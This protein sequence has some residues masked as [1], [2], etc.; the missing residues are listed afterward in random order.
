MFGEP[1]AYME[2]ANQDK[3]VW[4]NVK[5]ADVVLYASE[6][7]MSYHLG[8]SAQ[9]NSRLSLTP[10]ECQFY[11]DFFV[12]N[13][14]VMRG[15]QLQ[16]APVG[17]NSPYQI[18]QQVSDMKGYD[19][20]GNFVKI[21]LS[22]AQHGFQVLDA[23]KVPQITLSTTTGRIHSNSNDSAS[24]PT[25]SW[26]NNS[27]VG[28]YH[29]A[30][31]IIGFANLGIQ[32]ARLESYGRLILSNQTMFRTGCNYLSVI[33][34]IYS[35]CNVELRLATESNLTRPTLTFYDNNRDV[36]H[37]GKSLSNAFIYTCNNN[38]DIGTKFQSHLFIDPFGQ[39]GLKTI[40]PTT[41]LVINNFTL[42]LSNTELQV[43]NT[44]STASNALYAAI[45]AGSS[46]AG[47]CNYFAFGYRSNVPTLIV[48]NSND[49]LTVHLNGAERLRLNSNNG[50]LGIF[51]NAPK[52]QVDL[53][54]EARMSSNVF[55]TQTP[56]GTLAINTE[57]PTPAHVHIE[58]PPYG[59][60]YSGPSNNAGV[61]INNT[62]AAGA[63][64]THS[65]MCLQTNEGNPF[66]SFNSTTPAPR[67]WSVGIDTADSKKL[68][69]AMS[70]SN[71]ARNTI[72]TFDSNLSGSGFNVGV[73]T[74][75]PNAR[76]VV[77][78]GG[79][80]E[81]GPDST[82]SKL[83]VQNLTDNFDNGYIGTVKNSSDWVGIGYRPVTGITSTRPEMRVSAQA[84]PLIYRF[85]NLARMVSM[86]TTFNGVTEARMGINFANLDQA[87][88]VYPN[89]ALEVLG[90]IR[91]SIDVIT[92][93]DSRLKANLA[94]IPEPLKKVNALTGYTYDRTDEPACQEQ[95]RHVGLIAQQVEQVLPE[96]V[97]TDKSSGHLSIA[98]GN[99]TALLVEA[100]K[101][102]TGRMDRLET[103]IESLKG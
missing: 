66:V 24:E 42:P 39:I 76:L 52:Y 75:N 84:D 87:A 48:S 63:T 21:T 89:Y 60:T 34:Q 88:P 72:M 41:H 33:P 35:N 51:S 18:T 94:A 3:F 62:G 59:R 40:H 98:Y 32:S 22:N 77:Y 93:S 50:Y 86:V 73:G 83:Y 91:S 82:S 2:I 23:Q 5:E 99:F 64:N 54:G 102:L 43:Q 65:I 57:T 80:I 36:L 8:A 81:S 61:Y 67:G 19:P 26:S 11:N 38:L 68:K 1:Y 13:Q 30:D 55:L 15:I 100:I 6:C 96:A 20:W 16:E 28:I 58:V 79:R 27:N 92:T 45:K 44:A 90:T 46:G 37:M 70:W 25:Y 47:N 74:S 71:L 85:G 12:T 56:T 17:D 7:N 49:P 78:N 95:K 69:V 10:S 29:Y 103:K 4:S 53:V 9:A 101:E 14:M 31:D 97:R